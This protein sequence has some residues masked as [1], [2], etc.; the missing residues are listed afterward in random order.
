MDCELAGRISVIIV[1]RDKKR[2]RLEKGR[3]FVI[4]LQFGVDIHF[5][6]NMVH[7]SNCLPG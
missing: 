3:Y 5:M 7:G 1:S 6:G 2:L 4:H